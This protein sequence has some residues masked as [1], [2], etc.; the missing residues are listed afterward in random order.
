[1][2]KLQAGEP[3]DALVDYD[4]L[5]V[6]GEALAMAGVQGRHV[7][8][9]N[10]LAYKRASLAVLKQSAVAGIEDLTVLK[11]WPN[12]SGSFVRF[13]TEQALTDFLAR[14]QVVRVHREWVI[15]PLTTESLVLINQ[16]SVVA[17]GLGG[18]GK[19]IAIF[20]TGIDASLGVFG[21]CTSTDPPMPPETCRVVA[22]ID[23]AGDA[24]PGD[25]GLHGTL[26]SA[27][28]ATVAPGANLVFADVI[29]GNDDNVASVGTALDWVMEIYDPDDMDIVAINMSFR[30]A[31]EDPENPPPPQTE[32]CTGAPLGAMFNDAMMAGIQ[33]IAA[34][35]NGAALGPMGG[36]IDGTKIPACIPSVVSV[37]SV[38][39]AD[40]GT[41]ASPYGCTDDT[42][43]D[44]IGCYSQTASFLDLLAPGSLINVGGVNFPTQP[45]GTSFAAPHVAG[46]W[47]VMAEA[48]PDATASQIL[49]TLKA[50]GQDIEDT[51]VET[52]TR[53][54]PRL[55]LAEALDPDEDGVMH[56]FDNCLEH[57]NPPGTQMDCDADSDGYGN[58]CDC[59]LTQEGLCDTGDIPP[60]KL[61]LTG[62]GANPLIADINCSGVA[63]TGDIPPFKILIQEPPRPGPSGFHCGGTP[64][65]C[66]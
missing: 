64:P 62:G 52:E 44:K 46:A 17:G 8:G 49:E 20:D 32:P 40:V 56:P 36:F 19:V 11:E 26:V 14:P 51:R 60:F 24:D 13:E 12:L 41:Q 59:D 33:P 30:F 18:A 57:A 29:S 22:T 35:G 50:S 3:V 45:T 16:P 10:E 54:T 61:A 9:P 58:V 23:P 15:E 4:T 38:Y 47:A 21:S 37:G 27:I 65:P 42:A 1:V 53:I 34:A 7:L 66:Q 5:E 43:A 63:D 55:D 2:A 25:P 31:Y 39:D 6:D 28:A 48:F